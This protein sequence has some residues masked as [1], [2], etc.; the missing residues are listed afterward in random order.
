MSMFRKTADLTWQ[1]DW[2]Y[3]D[4]VYVRDLL[5]SIFFE[6]SYEIKTNFPKKY[7][8]DHTLEI[9]FENEA[10]EAFFIMRVIGL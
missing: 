3:D 5:A 6:A 2:C 4:A 10:E 8:S 1:T 9:K 7:Y